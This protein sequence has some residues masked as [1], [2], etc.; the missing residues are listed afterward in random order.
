MARFGS[1]I[2][3]VPRL[4]PEYVHDSPFPTFFA[5]IAAV[6]IFTRVLT[7]IQNAISRTHVDSPTKR[8]TSIPYWVPFVGSAVSFATDIQGTLT[9]GRCVTTFSFHKH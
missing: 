4:L 2:P 9:K 6:C 1:L 5:L 7:G 3:V 8:A